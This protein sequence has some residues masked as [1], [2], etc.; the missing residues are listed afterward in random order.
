MALCSS[1]SKQFQP[2]TAWPEGVCGECI[3]AQ[4]EL[5]L[6]R[7]VM[8]DERKPMRRAVCEQGIEVTV[9]EVKRQ[10]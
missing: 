10:A 6:L 1:C 8:G 5:L 2:M 4:L 9:E 7:R 3:A